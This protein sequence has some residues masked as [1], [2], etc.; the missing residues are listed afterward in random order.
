M[1]PFSCITVPLG[2]GEVCLSYFV[3]ECNGTVA[4][5]ITVASQDL[6]LFVERTVTQ[7]NDPLCVDWTAGCQI[8]LRSRA[9][10]VSP[11][12]FY[13][14]G[15]IDLV[16]AGETSFSYELECLNVGNDCT[17]D[18]KDD[19]V[20]LPNHCGWC[21]I[22]GVDGDGVCLTAAPNQ[23]APYCYS[24][25]DDKGKNA[26]SVD[27]GSGSDDSYG[28]NENGGGKGT[29][30]RQIGRVVVPLFA[31]FLLVIG[32]CCAI[33]R[34]KKKRAQQNATARLESGVD[35]MDSGGLASEDAIEHQHA[36]FEMND[37]AAASQ[38]DDHD[39]DRE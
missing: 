18:N 4:L 3:D 7:F 22:G 27:G 34:C 10:Y 31:I 26:W 5:N 23:N 19:C 8:C 12:S 21:A 35:G 37:A 25:V 36:Q 16:C 1:S 39:Q 9:F 14:C 38:T 24:C 11:A 13:T 32:A 28:Q 30:A 15:V 33:R 2:I 29:K 17:A 6:H 20:A